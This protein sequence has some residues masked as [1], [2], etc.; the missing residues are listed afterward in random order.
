MLKAR[1]ITAID[2]LVLSNYDEDHVSDLSN[3][4][5]DRIH[6]H[7]IVGNPTVAMGTLRSLKS[8]GIGKGIAS[9]IDLKENFGDTFKPRDIKDVYIYH[10]WIIHNPLLAQSTNDLSLVTFISINNLHMV[11]PGDIEA[12]GWEVLLR[13]QDFLAHLKRVRGCP[14]LGDSGSAQNTI[15]RVSA[16]LELILCADIAFVMINGNVSSIFCPDGR[17]KLA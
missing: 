4:R 3:I 12:A 13:R 10:F 7:E 1:G 11:F 6:I 16:F 9:L 17:G 14:Q 2:K 15:H 5:Q 8:N